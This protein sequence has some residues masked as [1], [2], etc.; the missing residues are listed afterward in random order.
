MKQWYAVCFHYMKDLV[1][2]DNLVK[3]RIISSHIFPTTAP[4]S[5][6][7]RTQIVRN[8]FARSDYD[9]GV[10]PHLNLVNKITSI[11]SKLSFAF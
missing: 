3:F 2:K 11:L 8:Y 5:S 7:G 4:Q 1:V 9:V 10:W 6:P